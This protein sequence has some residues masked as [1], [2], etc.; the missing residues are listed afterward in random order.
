MVFH[1]RET[2]YVSEYMAWV[3]Y[4]KG[5]CPSYC[6]ECKLFLGRYDC[7]KCKYDRIKS[8]NKCVCPKGTL[9]DYSGGPCIKEKD[10]FG[11]ILY[12]DFKNEIK[13]KIESN[14]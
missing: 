5:I 3:Y 4:G 10:Y 7:I 1:S 9:E 14:S 8:N 13:D 2:R 12:Y 6:D 11:L